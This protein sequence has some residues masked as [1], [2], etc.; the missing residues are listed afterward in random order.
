MA[1]SVGD[2]LTASQMNKRPEACSGTISITPSAANTPTSGTVPFPFTFSNTPVVVATLNSGNSSE[3]LR[4]Y[5][6][7]TSTTGCTL[8]LTSASST[9]ARTVNWVAVGS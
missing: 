6:S 4:V 7:G 5:V 9:T 1:Y 2:P 3:A 8:W